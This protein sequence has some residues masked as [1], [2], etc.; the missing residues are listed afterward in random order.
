MKLE[1]DFLYAR[2]ALIQ[3][4]LGTVWEFVAVLCFVSS[5]LSY[6]FCVVAAVGPEAF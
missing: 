5:R 3:M 2:V 1:P 4:L 6:K